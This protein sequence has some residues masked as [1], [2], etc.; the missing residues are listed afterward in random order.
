MIT[1]GL[2]TPDEV[3]LFIFAK[4]VKLFGGINEYIDD[5]LTKIMPRI[6]DMKQAEKIATKRGAI[7]TLNRM[8]T[9]AGIDADHVKRVE[10]ALEELQAMKGGAAAGK[11][12]RKSRKNR[13]KTHRIRK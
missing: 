8:K 6:R 10:E 2:I 13:N 7:A 12:S 9:F 5:F 3:Q 11:K 1:A 4:N